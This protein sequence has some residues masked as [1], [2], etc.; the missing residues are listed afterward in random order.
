M[1][2]VY[3]SG[4]LL[5]GM[6]QRKSAI[7]FKPPVAP[8]TPILLISVQRVNIVLGAAV[9]AR[10][11]LRPV[12]QCRDIILAH[13]AWCQLSRAL[14]EVFSVNWFSVSSPT[15]LSWGIYQNCCEAWSIP[16]RQP[17]HLRPVFICAIFV[18]GTINFWRK[19]L[20]LETA[21]GNSS[22]LDG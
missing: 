6:Q 18:A 19:V 3:P 15:L 8:Q 2:P 7:L 11:R 20:S 4:R 12:I 16:A 22:W 5:V 21:N 17:I 10:C 13:L 14:F 1:L 9:V